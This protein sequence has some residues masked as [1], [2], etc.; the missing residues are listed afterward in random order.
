[1]KIYLNKFF[2]GIHPNKSQQ[3]LRFLTNLLTNRLNL[4][5]EKTEKKERKTE[6][7]IKNFS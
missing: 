6:V 1:M 5:L 3:N 4:L 2:L 7:E